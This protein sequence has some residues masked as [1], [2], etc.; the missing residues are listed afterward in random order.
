[1]T[2]QTKSSR[3]LREPEVIERTGLSSPTLWRK[4]KKNDF[5]RRIK[6]GANSVGWLESEVDQWIADR[7]SSRKF[8]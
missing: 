8:S 6:I 4:E 7:S 3:I 5:P 2:L 1:M